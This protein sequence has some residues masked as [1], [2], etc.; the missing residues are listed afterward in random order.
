MNSLLSPVPFS[1]E[2]NLNQSRHIGSDISDVSSTI[3]S[4]ARILPP[5]Q[6]GTTT[7]AIEASAP[8]HF[9]F[10]TRPFPFPAS[11]HHRGI[12]LAPIINKLIS[13]V[14]AN[15]DFLERMMAPVATAD[16]DFIGR[17][18][19]IMKSCQGKEEPFL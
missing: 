7:F 19:K 13:R 14:A 15:H 1:R 3:R 16:P 18:M 5:H 8:R 11:F 4:L 6:N 9:P 17:L 10:T 2:D 12:A